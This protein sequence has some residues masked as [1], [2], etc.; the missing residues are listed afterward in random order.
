MN[1]EY[2]LKDLDLSKHICMFIKLTGEEELIRYLLNKKMIPWGDGSLNIKTYLNE[3][4][5]RDY[6][7]LNKSELYGHIIIYGRKI[8]WGGIII[9]NLDEVERLIK[10]YTHNNY[11]VINL[12]YIKEEIELEDKNILVCNNENKIQEI[13]EIQTINSEIFLIFKNSSSRKFKNMEEINKEY[14][15]I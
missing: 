8:Y 4:A 6:Y 13:K 12:I 7:G 11:K 5:D 9:T 15:C 3:R 10:K 2:Y 14:F 1:I